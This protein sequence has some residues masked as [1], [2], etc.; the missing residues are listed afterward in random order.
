[1]IAI[2]TSICSDFFIASLEG[3]ECNLNQ[4]RQSNKGHARWRW[5]AE[6]IDEGVHRSADHC[7]LFGKKLGKTE[8]LGG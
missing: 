7:V 3:H 5:K 4:L 2:P 1:M 8:L 6:P